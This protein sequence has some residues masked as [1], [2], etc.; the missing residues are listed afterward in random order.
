[1]TSEPSLLARAEGHNKLGLLANPE[2]KY[3]CYRSSTA[4]K[5]FF[6]Q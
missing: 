5:S 6:Q 2:I 1:M 4:I 3:L